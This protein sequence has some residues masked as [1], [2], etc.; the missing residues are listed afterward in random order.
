MRRSANLDAAG[1]TRAKFNYRPD[2]R[3]LRS[4]AGRVFRV[5]TNC[6]MAD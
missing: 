1:L 2:S 6:R 5:M 4:E 3:D